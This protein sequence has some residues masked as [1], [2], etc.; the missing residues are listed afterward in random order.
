MCLRI[1]AGLCGLLL[2]STAFNPAAAQSFNQFLGFGDSTIEGGWWKAALPGNA[3][4]FVNK[5]NLISNLIARGHSGS[6]VGAGAKM[7]SELVASYFDIGAI[8]AN[9]PGGTNYAVSRSADRL[10]KTK[11][12]LGDCRKSPHVRASEG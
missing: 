9:Q 10:G 12:E 6:P 5:D 11:T 1:I 3:T 4:G 8:P 2:S 7:G